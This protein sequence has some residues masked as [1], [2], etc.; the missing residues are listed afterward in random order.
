MVVEKELS[1]FIGDVEQNPSSYLP[2][3]VAY[4]YSL[5]LKV[6]M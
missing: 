4:S 2:H 5:L 6:A 1:L 3:D